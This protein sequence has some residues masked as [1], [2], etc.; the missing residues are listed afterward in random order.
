MKQK[1]VSLN[2]K[3]QEAGGQNPLRFAAQRN[4]LLAGAE[5]V[6]QQDRVA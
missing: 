2:R 1:I 6:A 5:K 4:K 3:Y